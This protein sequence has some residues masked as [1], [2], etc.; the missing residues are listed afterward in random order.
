MVAERL[1]AGWTELRRGKGQALPGE[2]PAPA[3]GEEPSQR[4]VGVGGSAG[5]RG[6]S[7]GLGTI[8][9]PFCEG[10]LPVSDGSS[11]GQGRE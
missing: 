11:E 1:W 4:P 10:L 2:D 5:R 6:H 3:P 9:G 8:T 7:G